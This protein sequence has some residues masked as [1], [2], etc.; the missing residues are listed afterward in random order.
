MCWLC[1]ERR[2]IFSLRPDFGLAP[3]LQ[4]CSLGQVAS[5]LCASVYLS[6]NTVPIPTFQGVR[7]AGEGEMRSFIAILPWTLTLGKIRQSLVSIAF[8][9]WENKEETKSPV[10]TTGIHLNAFVSKAAW[11]QAANVSLKFISLSKGTCLMIILW[12]ISFVP[13]V[14]PR[15]LWDKFSQ[16]I[17]FVLVLT[18]TPAVLIWF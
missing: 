14:L 8:D 11:Q 9:R 16:H 12:M 5:W 18:F 17:S 15:G 4:G 7:A 3:S 6:V 13:C 10:P 1:R 2:I